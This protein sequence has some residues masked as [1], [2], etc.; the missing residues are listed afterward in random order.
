MEVLHGTGAWLRAHPFGA[1]LLLG[2]ATLL[3][4]LPMPFDAVPGI[5]YRPA[6]PLAVTILL[7]AALPI[8]WR[9]R[10]PQAAL[11]VGGGAAIAYELRGYPDLGAGLSALV[12]CYS[13][14]AHLP[15]GPA[16]RAGAL[17]LMG[18][19][20]ALWASPSPL[21]FVDYLAGMATFCAAWVLGDNLRTRRAYVEVLEVRTE[22]AERRRRESSRQ[23]V[24][25]ERARIARELHDVVA[26]SMS[27]MVV[28]AG[29]ARRVLR[30]RPEVSEES[31][32]SIESTG[33]QALDEMRRLLGVLRSD[34]VTGT[35]AGLLPQP[36]LDDVDDLVIQCQEAGLPVQLAV[37]GERRPLPAGVELSAFRVVQEALTNSLK[38]A[39]RARAQVV[40]RWHDHALEISV[41]D[42]G[43]GASA[44]L[45]GDGGGHGLVGMEER[46][47]LYGGQLR[48][49]PRPGGGF[50]VRASFP[51]AS[52][53]AQR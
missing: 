10:Y 21:H 53:V 30:T 38:H 33:R 7:V 24:A 41:A 9:R 5:G 18:T 43:R 29:A 6:D 37:K 31:L 25:D 22:Q 47:E 52:P 2:G 28:Q 46:T 17:A 16:L 27:V 48:A 8:A 44:G 51:L 36:T 15:R 19:A 26:H 20:V 49:G 13:A 3:V 42:D 45:S 34:E 4:L 32:R 23:A 12:L 50:E 14:A 11:A 39:G 1:D 40:I 35:E